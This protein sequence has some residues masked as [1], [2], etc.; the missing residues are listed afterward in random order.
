MVRETFFFAFMYVHLLSICFHQT[1]SG[2]LI[3]GVSNEAVT[4]VL[5]S[6]K[7]TVWTQRYRSAHTL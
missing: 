6:N 3:P 1:N 4:E 7:P 2:L 5:P